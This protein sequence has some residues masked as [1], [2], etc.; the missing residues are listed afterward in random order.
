M[1]SDLDHIKRSWQSAKT[2]L[3]AATAPV[4]SIISEAEKKKRRSVY[5]QYGNI[6][7]LTATLGMITAFFYFV[8]PVQDTM[9]LAGKWLMIGGLAVRIVIEVFSIFKSAQVD[10]ADA[11]LQSVDSALHYYK[12]RKRIHG[13]VT[14]TIVAL[15][16]LGFYILTPEFSRYIELPWLI[17]FDLSYIFGAVFLV[18]QIRKGIRREMRELEEM[19]VLKKEL[20]GE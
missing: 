9:S 14:F 17:L 18:W 6:A 5:F 15:Y 10:L 1:N 2:N 4:E 7:I 13:S 19:V 16:T 12:F 3:K 20:A 8:A 11:A